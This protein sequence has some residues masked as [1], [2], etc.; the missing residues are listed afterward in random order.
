MNNSNETNGSKF[1]KRRIFGFTMLLIL[2]NPH[3]PIICIKLH[4][5]YTHGMELK[6]EKGASNLEPDFVHLYLS[7][8]LTAALLVRS[9]H[10]SHNLYR[11]ISEEIFPQKNLLKKDLNSEWALKETFY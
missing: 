9:F 11:K 7:R 6:C 3:K 1:A 2:G 8:F 10:L 5:P 4:I